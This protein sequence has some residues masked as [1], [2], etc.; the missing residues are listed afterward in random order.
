MS[1]LASVTLVDSDT[2]RICESNPHED[3]SEYFVRYEKIKAAKSIAEARTLGAEQSDFDWLLKRGLM[4]RMPPLEK[5]VRAPK[6]S[7]RSRAVQA[8]LADTKVT[9]PLGK[10]E[11]RQRPASPRTPA[12]EQVSPSE[13]AAKRVDYRGS[14]IQSMVD[15]EQIQQQGQREQEVVPD[16]PA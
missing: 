1:N 7:S 15:V 16:S 9:S 8:A 2:I 5:P 6:E 14:P 12:K 11:S 4:E 3:G 13:P 10:F